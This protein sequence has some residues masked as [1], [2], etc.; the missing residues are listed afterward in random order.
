[1]FN[2]SLVSNSQTDGRL[3][4]GRIQLA[5]FSEIFESSLEYW[6]EGD[7]LSQWYDGIFR[8]VNRKQESCLITS[9][10]DPA[11]ANF[12]FWWPIYIDGLNAIFQNQVL[13]LDRLPSSFDEK[14]PYASLKPRRSVSDE[15]T[16]ISEWTVPIMD[17]EDWLRIRPRPVSDEG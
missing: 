11:S 7:Y 1:M 9:V 5:D 17:L 3:C 14:F 13:F 8:V 10:T 4:H 2:I 6:K 12:L 16:K 15:G